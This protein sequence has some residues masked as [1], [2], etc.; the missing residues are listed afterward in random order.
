[1]SGDIGSYPKHTF[2]RY[3]R[4]VL[5]DPHFLALLRKV[6]HQHAE[7][8]RSK[9]EGI[10][11]KLVLKSAIAY[12]AALGKLRGLR[13]WLD[14]QRFMVYLI[15]MVLENTTQGLTFGGLD[16][17]TGA[18]PEKGVCFLSSHRSTFLDPALANYVLFKNLGETAHNAAG[19]NIFR[20][21]WLGHLIRLNKGFMV[22]REVEDMDEKL[23][24]AHKLSTYIH[25]LLQKK[26]WVWIAHRNG[27]AKDGRDM[28]DS[29]VLSM[30]KM[31]HGEA[32]WAEF[33]SAAPLLPIS[34]SWELV[35]LDDLMAQELNG[36]TQ[37]TGKHRDMMNIMTEIRIAKKR[38]H[39]QF[40]SPVFADKRA[41]LVKNFDREIH[42]N[43][44]LWEANWVAYL[45]RLSEVDSVAAATLSSA[46]VDQVDL[47]KGQWVLA[48]ATEQET[49]VLE[50]LRSGSLKA[51]DSDEAEYPAVAAKVRR[52]LID[53]YAAPVELALKAMDGN[54]AEV[55]ARQRELT[56]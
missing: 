52:T 27:R 1:M 20:T 23:L 37:H 34:M 38:I 18:D 2:S 25:R 33:S 8:P 53:M 47:T 24:E 28:T 40:G 7:L 50:N 14:F 51:P 49:E 22:K 30:L 42:L 9:S 6:T 4:E 29:A 39:L 17:V 16:K 15:D 43:T 12:H 48:R 46:L 54:V 26:E 45:S 13:S 11:R 5:K 31:A 32:D 19:D 10:R 21:S 55:L 36:I 3:W 44:R 41:T 35:P 56:A